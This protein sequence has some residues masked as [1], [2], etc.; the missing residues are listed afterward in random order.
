MQAESV[1][2]LPESSPLALQDILEYVVLPPTLVPDA[3]HAPKTT[4]ELS[5]E[6]IVPLQP[7]EEKRETVYP[8][9]MGVMA[10]G[11]GHRVLE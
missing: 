5:F 4:G 3:A 10:T 11:F 8:L 1:Y 2:D 9:E 6:M 7:C